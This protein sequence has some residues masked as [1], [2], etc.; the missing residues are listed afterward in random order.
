MTDW[1]RFWARWTWGYAAAA[2]GVGVLAA[3]MA[4]GRAAVGWGVGALWGWFNA[5]LLYRLLAMALSGQ[6][7]QKNL[8]A[9]CLIKFPLLY[10]VGLGLLISGWFPLP[11]LVGG[12][13]LW[14]FGLIVAAFVKSQIFGRRGE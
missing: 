8:F 13:A 10:L 14:V 9:M 7:K 6:T 4:D 2:V 5:F 3:I 11:W 12:S 1:A